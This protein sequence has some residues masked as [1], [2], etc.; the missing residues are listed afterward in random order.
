MKKTVKC[1]LLV[2]AFSLLCILF[3]ALSCSIAP[4]PTGYTLTVHN[5]VG[6]GIAIWIR[7]F[8]QPASYADY[9][10]YANGSASVSLELS[11]GYV[12]KV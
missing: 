6:S 11:P 8:S 12:I 5:N 3:S 9:G 10:P 4:I 1:F 2:S 7:V